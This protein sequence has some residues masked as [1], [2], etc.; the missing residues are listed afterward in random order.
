MGREEAGKLF[1]T[2]SYDLVITDRQM[3]FD[4]WLGVVS[5]PQR[6][7]PEIPCHGRVRGM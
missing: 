4:E 6:A 1:L 3:P 5:A 2:G 7:S